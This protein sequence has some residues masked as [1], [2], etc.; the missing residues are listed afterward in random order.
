[1]ECKRYLVHTKGIVN[2]NL[3]PP[4]LTFS[5]NSAH[6]F[7]NYLFEPQ[8]KHTKHSIQ[9]CLSVC[10]LSTLLLK[11]NFRTATI[12]SSIQCHEV[13]LTY[14]ICIWCIHIH[15]FTRYLYTQGAFVGS[16][17]Q[18]MREIDARTERYFVR[19]TNS[20]GHDQKY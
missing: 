13:E 5:T 18:R 19:V 6:Q 7:W 4:P 8:A 1:M 9:L 10:E 15:T 12:Y 16:F 14:Y 3:P 11:L 2:Q 17:R 20:F